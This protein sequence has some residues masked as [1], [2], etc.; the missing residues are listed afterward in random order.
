MSDLIRIIYT[1]F[2]KLKRTLAIKL[3]IIAPFT[4]VFLE[5]CYALQRG[6]AA[7]KTYECAWIGFMQHSVVFWSLL[8]L[9]LF[10]TLITALLAGQEHTKLN[11]KLNCTL[12]VPTWTI[13][14]A[15]QIEALLLLGLTFIFLFS[16][17]IIMGIGMSF[18]KPIIGFTLIPPWPRFFN[19]VAL[20]YLCSWLIISIHIWVGIRW[21]SFVIAT[22]FG[23][24]MTVIGVMVI[25]S[26][27]GQFYP[28]AAPGLFANKFKDN[29][30]S[31]PTLWF[32][33]LG[34][35][36]TNILF[37]FDLKRREIFT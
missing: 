15:K 31:F 24:V 6:E 33:F 5:S 16:F 20:V 3:L 13:Y 37:C 17:T 29:I 12:P 34:G 25:N 23:I 18:L 30:M 11:W 19:H 1:D 21:D 22:G 28:W 27:F 8:M 26:K 32:G 35:I 10:T 4:P 36:T 7:Y 14:A 2:L 9:P